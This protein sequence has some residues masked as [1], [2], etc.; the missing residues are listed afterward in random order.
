MSTLY[1]SWFSKV[2]DN[3]TR[4]K[5]VKILVSDIVTLSERLNSEQV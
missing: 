5:C 2:D 4:M 3:K 1:V